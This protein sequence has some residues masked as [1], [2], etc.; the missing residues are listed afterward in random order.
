M[1][2]K[3]EYVY[4][5]HA[6]SAL[7]ETEPERII[8]VY[9]LKGR[10]DARLHA[11]VSALNSLGIT[12]NQ[13][14]RKTLDDKVFGG[15]H[16]GVV[17]RVKSAKVLGD[18]ELNEFLDKVENPFLLILDNVTD[19]HNLGACLRSCDGAGVNA[20][21]TSK[22]KSAS[23][24]AAAKKVACGAAESVPV[25]Y[26]TNLA[27]TMKEL[28]ERFIRIIGTAGET[29]KV[30]Y[31]VDLT[32]PL[33]LVM[34]AEDTGMRRLTRENCDQL[35]KLPMLGKVTSLNVS[36]ATGVCLYEALRQRMLKTK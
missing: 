21:I 15:V 10:D 23:L 19:V 2:S 24:T 4:G 30:I 18:Y 6:V 7:I 22:D 34:G 1:S 28:Q 13:V 8:E 14:N 25:F 33:A 5:V 29:D 35:V 11:V 3:N 9:V 31:D 36:V 17:A 32:G 26:V 12:V 27:R 16:Q 20:L